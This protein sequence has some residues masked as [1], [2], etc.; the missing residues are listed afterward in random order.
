MKN[1][2][3]MQNIS[4][5]KESNERMAMYFKLLQRRIF[6]KKDVEKESNTLKHRDE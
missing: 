1:V 6:K 4:K 3:N 5:T 2:E